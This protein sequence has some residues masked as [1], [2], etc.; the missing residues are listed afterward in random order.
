MLPVAP[1][2]GWCG[3]VGGLPGLRRVLQLLAEELG[4]GFQALIG[5]RDEQ[6]V[7]ALQPVG[8][9]GPV[10]PASAPVSVS[11]LREPSVFPSAGDPGET[12]SLRTIS[13][14]SPMAAESTGWT[15]SPFSTIQTI[16]MAQSA[17]VSEAVAR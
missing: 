1:D 13:S 15:S 4:E 3:T 14:D 9:A 6:R 10:G 11:I 5:A 16:S 17:M 8:V 2:P 7:A 12:V